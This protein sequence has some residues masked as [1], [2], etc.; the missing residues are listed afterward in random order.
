MFV[1]LDESGDLGFD[2]NKF[3]TTKKFIIAILIC[4]SNN[5][6]SEF[7]KAVRR[8]LKNKLN[9]KKCRIDSRQV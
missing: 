6:R 2:Y 4:Y 8:T 3:K 9:R 1:Y 7:K 5:A